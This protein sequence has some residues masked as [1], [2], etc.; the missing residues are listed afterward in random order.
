MVGRTPQGEGMAEAVNLN[1]LFRLHLRLTQDRKPAL[2]GEVMGKIEVTPA[3]KLWKRDY[4]DYLELYRRINGNVFRGS[5]PA[6][7][8]LTDR[9]G[10]IPDDEVESE[11]D[12]RKGGSE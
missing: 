4:Q 1:E 5:G 2:W 11:R 9:F 6:D 10:F 3:G 8:A 12:R 7:R